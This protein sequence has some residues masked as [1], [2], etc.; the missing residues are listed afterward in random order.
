[1]DK[2]GIDASLGLAFSL[3]LFQRYKQNGVLKARL[4]RVP[5][6]HG[7]CQAFLHLVDGNL[8]SVLLEDAQGQRHTSD[9]EALC[10]LDRERG[11]YEW[12]LIPHTD[13]ADQFHPI[14]SASSLDQPSS[15]AVLASVTQPSSRLKAISAFPW[16]QLASLSM[17]QRNM[18]FTIFTI[19]NEGCTIE[20]IKEMMPLPPEQVDN[21]VHTLLQLKVIEMY[22]E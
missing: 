20:D 9:K 13:I 10:R 5:G 12:T 8:V 18:L 6:L 17:E 21:M 11:P 7:P 4:P 2:D 1:M 22:T 15:A 16:D 3:E 19:I 14:E